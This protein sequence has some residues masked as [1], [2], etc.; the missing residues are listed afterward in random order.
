MFDDHENLR[1]CWCLGAC[2]QEKRDPK[3]G[4]NQGTLGVYSEKALLTCCTILQYLE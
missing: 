4:A 3:F 1:P 2:W